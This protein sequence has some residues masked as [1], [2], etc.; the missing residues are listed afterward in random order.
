[1]EELILATFI[2]TCHTEGCENA[3]IGIAVSAD[4]ANPIVVCGPC[5]Q[6]ITDITPVTE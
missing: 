6:T 1:M 3:G 2:A 5:S 4:A